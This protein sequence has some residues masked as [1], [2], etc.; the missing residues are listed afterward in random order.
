MVKMSGGTGSDRTYMWI[1]PDPSVEP[2]TNDAIVKR[3]SSMPEGFDPVS[4]THLRA[5]ETPEHIV[6]RLLL[7]KKK[8]KKERR[9]ELKKE[10]HSP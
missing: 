3:N 5:H 2:D 9:K 4:Y 1:D 8:R 6:C 10:V 7:E